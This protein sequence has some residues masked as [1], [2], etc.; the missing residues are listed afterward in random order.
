MK[1]DPEQVQ[2][3]SPDLANNEEFIKALVDS[4]AYLDE[5]A[6]VEV[7]K[8]YINKLRGFHL[9]VIFDGGPHLLRENREFML[10][11]IKR[12]PTL[13]KY[14]SPKLAS[15][16]ECMLTVIKRDPTLIKYTS[17]KLASNL[18]FIAEL[19]NDESYLLLLNAPKEI[20]L[21]YMDKLSEVYLENEVEYAPD[22]L[23]NNSTF[24]QY[25]TS[26]FCDEKLP[27][28]IKLNIDYLHQLEDQKQESQEHVLELSERTV[29]QLMSEP[30]SDLMHLE[31]AYEN[32]KKRVAFQE[33]P[34]EVQE[35]IE[36][37][38]LVQSNSLL[39][40]AL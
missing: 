10:T 29:G 34:K 24:V 6:P 12:D 4:D 21:A 25:V 8:A 35:L 39:K 11:V 2:Y 5:L 20:M 22:E 31:E 16:S 1:R 32:M 7:W 37:T 28:K 40:D 26:K 3:A 38:Q 36:N 13:I 15:D 30:K 17:P 33:V 18:E 27:D 19:V 23:I 9:S 14:T